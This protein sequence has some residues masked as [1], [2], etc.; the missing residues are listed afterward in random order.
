MKYWPFALSITLF[1]GL[2][3]TLPELGFQ[4][5]HTLDWINLTAHGHLMKTRGHYLQHG[6]ETLMVARRKNSSFLNI[7]DT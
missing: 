1:V 6:K 2:N 3:R 4:V 5:I 7:S